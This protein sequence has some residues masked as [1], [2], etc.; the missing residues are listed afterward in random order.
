MSLAY[1][2]DYSVFDKKNSRELLNLKFAN[3]IRLSENDDLPRNNQIGQKTSNFFSEISYKLTD[4]QC[5]I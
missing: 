1:G 5:K 3:N 4:F 2:S